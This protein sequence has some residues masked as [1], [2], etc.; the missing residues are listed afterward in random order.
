MDEGRMDTL[1]RDRLHFR[2][3]L[4]AHGLVSLAGGQ[5]DA[6]SWME[7][8]IIELANSVDR[9]ERFRELLRQT[10]ERL[11]QDARH[12]DDKCAGDERKERVNPYIQARFRKIRI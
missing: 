12:A 8:Q 6:L 2:N 3:L 4:D 5:E 10:R 11:T 1:R 7:T 9:R